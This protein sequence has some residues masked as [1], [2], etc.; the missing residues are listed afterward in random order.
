[1]A[2]ESGVTIESSKCENTWCVFNT[3]FFFQI[4][5]QKGIVT[6]FQLYEAQ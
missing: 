3:Y 5:T 4:H 2:N 1:M 6:D